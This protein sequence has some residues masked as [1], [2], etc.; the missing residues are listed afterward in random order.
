[1]QMVQSVSDIIKL[2]RPHQWIKNGFVFVGLIFGHHW[3]DLGY[4][5][6]AICGA[7]SFSLVSSGVYILND[8]FDIKSDQAHPKK[9][10]RPLASG[11]VKKAMAI[12]LLVLLLSTGIAIGFWTSLTIAVFLG[13]YICINIA[14]SFGLK[15]VVILD[16]FIISAGFM[17]RLLT[18]T[19]GIGIAPSNWLLFCG[20]MITLFLGFS[21]RRAE[22]LLQKESGEATRQVLEHYSA[23]LLD[24]FIGISLA[25][26]ILSYSLY[27]V[28]IETIAEHGTDKLIYTV[29]LVIYACFRYMYLL[30]M[31]GGGE[32]TAKDLVRDPHIMI[33]VILWGVVTIS[34]MMLPEL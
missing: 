9:K 29:P 14:Y 31:K 34:L 13:I 15:H 12:F 26:V 17:L 4:I 28:S 16:I 20:L 23:P 25:C 33:S 18:G 22:L 32:D 7:I 11:R 6:L 30:H 27:T 8:L 1:M 5:K 3:F 2:I 21:K 24:I 19:T 10:D